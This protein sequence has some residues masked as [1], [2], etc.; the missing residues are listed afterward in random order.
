MNILILASIFQ[1][2]RELISCS[3]V[4]RSYMLVFYFLKC[5]KFNILIL[6]KKGPPKDNGTHNNKTE[7]F[8]VCLLYYVNFRIDIIKATNSIN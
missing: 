5:F 2:T 1:G 6:R 8:M 4:H 3:T 7:Y